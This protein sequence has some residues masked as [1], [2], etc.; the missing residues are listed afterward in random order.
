MEEYDI[1][2]EEDEIHSFITVGDIVDYIS[3][4]TK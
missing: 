2:I 4:H 3:A 1:D